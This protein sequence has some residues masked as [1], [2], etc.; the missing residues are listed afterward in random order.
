MRF[1][2]KRLTS[3]LEPAE[4]E[5]FLFIAYVKPVFIYPCSMKLVGV[6]LT[7]DVLVFHMSLLLSAV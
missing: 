5:S 6:Q 1:V 7:L 2:A 4:H 3:S